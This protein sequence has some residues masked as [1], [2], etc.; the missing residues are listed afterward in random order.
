MR[1]NCLANS[2]R[3]RL[4]PKTPSQG[5]GLPASALGW[6]LP[7]LWAGNPSHNAE[8]KSLFSAIEYGK[9]SHGDEEA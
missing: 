8:A 1:K 4:V 6:V 5:I 9:S 3:A 7:A 2:F